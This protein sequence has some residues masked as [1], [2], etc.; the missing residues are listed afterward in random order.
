MLQVAVVFAVRIEA[1]EIISRSLRSRRL[2]CAVH[3]DGDCDENNAAAAVDR[4]AIA[5]GF[6]WHRIRRQI[7]L[8]PAR[9]ESAMAARA[10]YLLYW[11]QS[12]LG[13][14][15]AKSAIIITIIIVISTAA[16]G[17]CRR[18]RLTD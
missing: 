2:V 1:G 7:S 14:F 11:I 10:F 4:S 8:V 12:S 6:E 5:S 18:V 9:H 16:T 3:D 17:F 15:V 13:G